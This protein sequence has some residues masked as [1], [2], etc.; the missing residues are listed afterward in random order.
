MSVSK[1][2]SADFY[3]QRWRLQSCGPRIKTPTGTLY[4]VVRDG[5][6]LMLKLIAPDGDEQ[7]SCNVLRHYEGQGAV[8]V[9]EHHL[10]AFVMERAN[11]GTNLSDFRTQHGDVAATCAAAGLVK[12]LHQAS[13][14]SKAH[15][16]P[17]L[18]TLR[19]A[20][21][22]I[23]PTAQPVLPSPVILFAETLFDRLIASTTRPLVLHGD[24]HHE[25]MLFDECRG[26]LVIDPKGYV[27]DPVYDCAALFKNP[28][29]D[30]GVAEKACILSRAQLFADHLEYPYERI[31]QWAFVHCVLSVIWSL[32]DNTSTGPA[33]PVALTLFQYI[34][35]E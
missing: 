11:P 25:N 22:A 7:Q 20:F 26:W 33:L 17:H 1:P 13:A 9:F 32:Q 12:T 28:L 15:D 4:P 18:S 21:A 27:G 14:P 6:L 8:R 30:A 29:C 5:C 19:G 2:G 23:P 3:K 34:Q 10:D 31:L 35:G 24:L 16:L